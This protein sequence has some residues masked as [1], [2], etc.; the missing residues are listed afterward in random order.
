VKAIPIV[1]HMKA[2]HRECEF[3]LRIDAQF[4]FLDCILNNDRL[5]GSWIQNRRSRVS[6][7]ALPDSLRS[8]ESGTGCTSLVRINDEHLES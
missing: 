2:I 5:C 7:Q 3:G 4:H 8:S 1:L 6:L